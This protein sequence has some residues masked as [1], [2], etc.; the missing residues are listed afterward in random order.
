MESRLNVYFAGPIDSQTKKMMLASLASVG[1]K[2]DTPDQENPDN[3][4]ILFFAEIDQ[5]LYTLLREASRNGLERVVAIAA[6]PGLLHNGTAW[7]L[8]EA[9]AADVFACHHLPEMTAQVVA[10]LERWRTIDQILDSP[11][12]QTNLVGQSRV[13]RSVLRQVIEV[14]RFTDAPVLILGE[15]GT[16]KELVARLIQT[17]DPRTNKQELIV[18][19]CT[20][21]VPELSGSE[22]FGHERGAF[23]GA[24]NPRDGAF[25]LANGGILFLDEVGELP[26]E[27]Q[28]QLLRVIQEHSYKRVGSNTWRHTDFRLICATNKDLLQSVAH[29]EFRCD[30]YYRIASWVCRL[31][32]LRERSEDILPLARH[33]LQELHPGQEPPELD[34]AV[35][36]Y[37]LGR[38]YPGNVRDLKQLVTRI[39]LRHVGIG[40]ISAGAIPEGERP[41]TPNSDGWCDTCFEQAVRRALA[42]GAGLKDI[43]RVAAETAIY[44]AIS[45]AGGNLHRAAH[46]LGVTDRA[47]QIRR[48]NHR[49][50][51]SILV[52]SAIQ[53]EDEEKHGRTAMP[54]RSSG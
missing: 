26:L 7:R 50:A 36:N 43:S 14:A 52:D 15:S 48:V 20:T 42:F 17:L 27:L 37:L 5:P 44:I 45:D 21:I 31:P 23:T 16:G 8:L 28:A 29:G 12:V 40:P 33:F 1:L 2:T 30:L 6:K 13:W 34:E 25:A 3:P 10:R 22:F 32:P 38:D 18:L 46:Q 51:K 4:S 41:N 11:L 9:G 35:Q 49:K 24:L 39:N 19:D 54:W 47:L 53:S